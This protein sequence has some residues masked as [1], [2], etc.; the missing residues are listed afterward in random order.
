MSKHGKKFIPLIEVSTE[1]VTAE[2]RNTAGI[3]GAA[4]LAAD[5]DA[6]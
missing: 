3:V 2:L 1:I 5:R 4:A 6:Q